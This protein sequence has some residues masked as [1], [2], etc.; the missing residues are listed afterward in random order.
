[1]AAGIINLQK[2][3]GGVTQISG[4]DGTGTTQ[5]VVPESGT[6]AT[7]DNL[8]INSLTNKATPVD[9]DNLKIQESGG[10]FKKLSWANLKATLFDGA[11]SL[12]ENGY[13]KFPTAM[14]GFIIQWGRLNVP[15]NVYTSFT[16]PIA[17]T[18]NGFACSVVHDGEYFIGINARLQKSTISIKQSADVP[19]DVNYI[20]IG[21]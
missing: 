2:A 15:N 14:G 19:A 4:I 9:T 21:Y 10:L 1:M 12:T 6:L 13:V 7:L 11:I 3:S 18:S 5:V 16:L 8:D 20:A 17:F